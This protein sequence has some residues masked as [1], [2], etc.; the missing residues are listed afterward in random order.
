[1]A[2]CSSICTTR[3]GRVDEDVGLPIGWSSGLAW[4]ACDVPTWV[5]RLRSL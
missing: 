2:A 5:T 4:S 3:V 1:M